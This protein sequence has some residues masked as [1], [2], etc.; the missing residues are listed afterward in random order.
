MGTIK[1]VYARGFKESSDVELDNDGI[2][3][4]Y[5]EGK[6]VFGTWQIVLPEGVTDVHSVFVNKAETV[7][8]EGFGD[9]AQAIT[10]GNETVGANLSDFSWTNASSKGAL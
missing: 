5:N 10:E 7:T 2:A 8:V 4:N 1:N 9:N 3:T 6:L